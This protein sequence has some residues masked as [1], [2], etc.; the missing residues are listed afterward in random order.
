MNI[1]IPAAVECFK[2][3][4]IPLTICSRTRVMVSRTNN[5]P[6]KKTTP[7]AV[8]QGI[9]M[10]RHTEYVKYAFSDIPGAMAMG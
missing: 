4:G 3:F 8:R 10:P 9:P 2:Q 6:D 7:R 5:T 1:P